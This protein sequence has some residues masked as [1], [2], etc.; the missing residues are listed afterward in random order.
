M[1]VRQ[2]LAMPHQGCL[3]KLLANAQLLLVRI[4]V[5]MLV[6]PRKDMN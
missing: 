6:A 2:R 1:N 5:C 4:Q 3:H